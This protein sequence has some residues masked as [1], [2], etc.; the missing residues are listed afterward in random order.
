M[1]RT[2]CSCRSTTRGPWFLL[3][4]DPLGRDVLV[5]A[6]VG[7]RL[8]LA[9]AFVGVLGALAVGAGDR[10]HRRIAGGWVERLLMAAADF[11]MVLPAI[12][13]V[14]ALR[15]VLPLVLSVPEVSGA[16]AW[17]SLVGWPGARG[18]P[19]ILVAE[20]Q[21]D[22]QKLRGRAARRRGV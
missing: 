11:V 14:L 19:S 15:G 20:R 2:A 12:Y 17:S 10:R 16:V 21:A 3:G 4:S 7:A 13:V 18:V 6:A 8:S 9:V 1:V 5:T 22:T